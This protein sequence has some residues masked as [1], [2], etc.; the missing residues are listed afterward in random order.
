MFSQASFLVTYFCVG[1]WKNV[2]FSFI[3]DISILGESQ[4]YLDYYACA[5]CIC[6]VFVSISVNNEPV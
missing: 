3:V 2:M 1:Y 4:T 6:D 5:K